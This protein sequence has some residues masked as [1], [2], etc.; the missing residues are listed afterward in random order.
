MKQSENGMLFLCF[1]ALIS[2]T[3][4]PLLFLSLSHSWA[5][6]NSACCVYKQQASHPASYAF[7]LSIISKIQAGI[8]S[9]TQKK[10]DPIKGI[11]RLQTMDGWMDGWMDGSPKFKKRFDDSLISN[12][13]NTVIMRL[14]ENFAV[15]LC[16]FSSVHVSS[17]LQQMMMI[18]AGKVKMMKCRKLGWIW[19]VQRVV[20]VFYAWI[21]I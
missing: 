21:R 20:T 11:K 9:S 7:K 16:T 1:N 6:I 19:I 12:R 18:W 2:L 17:I 15:I 5:R 10:C 14:S 13:T 3:A 8:G 4:L